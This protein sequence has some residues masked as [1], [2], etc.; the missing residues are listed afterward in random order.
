[1]PGIGAH[2]KG[3][4]WW[5]ARLPLP[6]AR[7]ILFASLVDDPSSD[8][9]FKNSGHEA[10]ERERARLFKIIEDLCSKQA[11]KSSRVYKEARD[12]ILRC[13]GGDMPQVLDPF[14]GG[15]SIPLEAFRLGLP[16]IASDLNPVPLLITRLQIDFLPRL[17]SRSAVSAKSRGS[18]QLSLASKDEASSGLFGIVSDLQFYGEEVLR[19]VTAA[20]GHLYPK[21][22]NGFT[23]SAY[24]WCRTVPSPNPAVNG[25][26][27]PLLRTFLLSKKRNLIAKPVIRDGKFSFEVE[28]S[29][30]PAQRVGTISRRGGRCI[31]SG[32]SIPLKYVRESARM[33]NVKSRL[34]AL[35]VEGGKGKEY[36]SPE[37]E[38]EQVVASLQFDLEPSEALPDKALGFRVQT[39]GITQH[40]QLYSPRQLKV[41][42]TLSD[43]IKKT[44]SR[45]KCHAI[46]AGFAD[47]GKSLEEGGDGATAYADFIT[48]C[49]AMVLDR[50][51]DFNNSLCTWKPSG[52]QLM[53]L[54]VR[55]AIPMVWDYAEANLLG[56]KGV[57]WSN[58]LEIFIESL[59][60][61]SYER[62]QPGSVRQGCADEIT[63]NLRSP[64]IVNTDPPYFDNIAYSDLSDVF[65]VWLRRTLGAVFPRTLSTILT[66]KSQELI[67]SP[68]RYSGDK[69]AATK[70][71]AE[72]FHKVFSAIRD[73]HDPRYPMAVY[74]AFKQEEEGEE[75]DEE[76]SD[77]TVP[78]ETGTGWSTLL[79]S[80][81]SAGFE[82]T[83]TIPIRASQQWRM[84][85]I[86]SNALA[87][88][89]VLICRP[90][91][92]DS[93]SSTKRE[94]LEDLK[95]EM[96]MA[97]RVLK[98][99]AIA[100][101]DVAQCA[102][103]PGMA[104]YSRFSEVMESDGSRMTV[105]T[106]LSLIN[107]ALD[108]ANSESEGDFDPDSR[109]AVAWF[110][111]HGFEEGLY[112]EAETLSKAKNT[113][114][115]GL[116]EAGVITSRAGK[117]KLIPIE[118][119]PED[120]NPK[121]DTRLTVWEATHHLIRVLET[122]GEEGSATL[123]RDMGAFGEVAR[124]LAYRLY[125]ICERKKWAKDALRYNGLIV[126]WS[127]IS[128]RSNSIEGVA[129][130]AQASLF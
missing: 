97:L 63:E 60:S 26:A 12:E 55:Q 113:S 110:E 103:G 83:G 43:Q 1:M 58:A 20:I 78:G 111:S 42:Q 44:H 109:W 10:I 92:K 13:S 27:T 61:V 54:F 72:G 5:W 19:H 122:K 8:E 99:A 130:P 25:A 116:V 100:P 21:T 70:F 18:N 35:V 84:R 64:I 125:S 117:V 118:L 32:V 47:D 82:I 49:L 107:Q 2:P 73:K 3:L 96:P 48:L 16:V 39:Y 52:D 127:D 4:H 50:C 91:P 121:A 98:Q 38:Q 6:A 114:T 9:R 112:G 120:W 53:H 7:A 90:R 79:E 108:E 71:F 95:K 41:L 119:L 14:C 11:A 104:V 31:F 36:I 75:D 85:S 89:I 77:R 106:A 124:D 128:K 15:G 30:D 101:V 87:S 65:Y 93:K 67:A 56:T 105:R 76:S 94:F 88:Y 62:L 28:K 33:G 57:C 86:G 22:Q 129:R 68:E 37:N 46:E 126:S 51:V 69:G 123:L 66:P 17:V 34:I 115:T 80:L 59:K 74:Y 45:I 23:P 81:I 24:L 29:E 102:I 40:Y